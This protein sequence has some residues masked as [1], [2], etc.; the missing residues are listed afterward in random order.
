MSEQAKNIITNIIGLILLAFG[1]FTLYYDKVNYLEFL[2]IIV[3]SIAL[4]TFQASV[5][6]DY[7]KKWLDKRLK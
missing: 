5:T 1:G 3:V 7:I 6:K 2:G 4:F